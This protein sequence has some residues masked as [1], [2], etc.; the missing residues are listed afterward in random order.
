[1][2]QVLLVILGLSIVTLFVLYSNSCACHDY[3]DIEQDLAKNKFTQN[4][5]WPAGSMENRYKMYKRPVVDIEYSD[6]SK[7][8]N[9]HEV[10]SYAANEHDRHEDRYAVPI[11]LLP[12]T[13]NYKRLNSD[14]LRKSFS[15]GGNCFIGTDSNKSSVGGN[16]IPGVMYV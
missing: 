5:S 9:L 15:F 10:G 16:R 3:A 13:Y 4:H 11:T 14:G 12:Y 6:I 1:M 8:G 7:Y 2:S